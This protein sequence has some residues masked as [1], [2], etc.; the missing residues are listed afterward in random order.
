MFNITK[1]DRLL[2]HA[3]FRFYKKKAQEQGGEWLFSISYLAIT[4]AQVSLHSPFPH[5]L[6]SLL[7]IDK[8]VYSL[9]LWLKYKS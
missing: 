1:F 4:S 7:S 2:K 9:W 8:M 5:Q 6:F 3:E